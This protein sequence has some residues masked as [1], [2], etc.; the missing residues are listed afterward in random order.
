MNRSWNL[1]RLFGIRIAVHATF[2]L[3]LAFAALEGALV[4]GP[5]GAAVQLLLVPVLFS[6]VV[7]HELGHVFMA[8]RFGVETDEI[9]ILPVGG[10][11]RL[12]RELDRP[13]DEILVALAG[14]AVNMALATLLVPLW[15][16]AGAGPGLLA[17][18]LAINVSLALFNLL[19]AFPM[20]GGRVLRA[21]LTGVVG[22][23]EATRI[24]ATC[25]QATAVALGLVGIIFS[26]WLIVIAVFLWSVAAQE[27]E[28][29]QLRYG[30]PERFE[31]Q[32]LGAPEIVEIHEPWFGSHPPADRPWGART[33]RSVGIWSPG[34]GWR[35]EHWMDR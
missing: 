3:I 22:A 9:L 33:W 10:V 8:R 14:P 30:G 18:L 15:I 25:G 7:A 24:S 2:V 19:P 5:I 34:R 31:G 23:L 11:A 35:I 17:H 16:A 29:A 20:D 6:F 4:G 27:K 1:G 13:G 21:W 26:P 32:L 12:H 28:L